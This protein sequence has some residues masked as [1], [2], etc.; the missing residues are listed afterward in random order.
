MDNDILN[1]EN[2][3]SWHQKIGY[4]RQ[5]VFLIDGSLKENVALGIPKEKID[6]HKL[7][8]VLEKAQ[9]TEFVKNL[10]QGIDTNI[11][12]RGAKISGGQR[13]RIGIARALYY[14]AEVLFFDEAT[15]ALDSETEEEITEAIKSIHNENLTMIIIAHREST[16]K[17]CDRVIEL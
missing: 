14:D 17:Y 15:S 6:L 9:L 11:G 13:Q 1:E 8:I 12:E 5:D 10:E 2:M 3:D 16:L 7:S 4:V